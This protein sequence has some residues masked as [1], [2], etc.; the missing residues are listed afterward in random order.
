VICFHGEAIGSAEAMLPPRG[1]G[2]VTPWC[3]AWG[4]GEGIP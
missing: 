3:G 4:G 2:P 1:A